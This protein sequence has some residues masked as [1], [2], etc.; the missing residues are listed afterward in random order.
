MIYSLYRILLTVSSAELGTAKSS[1]S[2]CEVAR[3]FSRFLEGETSSLHW[4]KSRF[5]F[6]FVC[7][8]HETPL[9]SMILLTSGMV[10]MPSFLTPYSQNSP[11]ERT[12]KMTCFIALRSDR[13]KLKKM[14][15]FYV[16]R[17]LLIAG[18]AS[19]GRGY[20]YYKSKIIGA[21]PWDRRQVM[22]FTGV[23]REQLQLRTIFTICKDLLRSK[24]D[25]KFVTKTLSF[26]LIQ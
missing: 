11:W 24:F 26:Q 5:S 2:S 20:E 1:P 10:K 23:G 12:L 14:F 16:G 6:L 4:L 7:R 22:L 25:V 18:F 13:Q 21:A 19:T 15:Y 3:F 9:V 17:P 8:W